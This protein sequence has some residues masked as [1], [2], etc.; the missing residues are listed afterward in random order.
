MSVIRFLEILP[1]L[2]SLKTSIADPHHFNAVPDPAF[3]SIADS[4]PAPLLGDGN[5][6]PLSVGPLGIHFEPPGLH[7]KRP[8]PSAALF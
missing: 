6:S 1:C 4:D 3:H 2:R 8:R 5:L 7:F